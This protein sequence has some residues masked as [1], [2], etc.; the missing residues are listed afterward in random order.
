MQG[1]RRARNNFS[2]ILKMFGQDI[3]L[4]FESKSG[5]KVDFFFKEWSEVSI[6]EFG[7]PSSSLEGK[8]SNM[9]DDIR[10]N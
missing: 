1:S 7:L 8:F 6:F 10:E 9:C 5:F 3:R 4:Y 2:I